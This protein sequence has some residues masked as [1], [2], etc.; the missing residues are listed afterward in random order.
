MSKLKIPALSFITLHLKKIN[1]SLY[2][3]RFYRERIPFKSLYTGA[4]LLMLASVLVTTVFVT[5]QK[6][7]QN[8]TVIPQPVQKEE[9][10]APTGVLIVDKKTALPQEVA[11]A[12]APV[13]VKSQFSKEDSGRFLRVKGEIRVN[14]GWH[15]HPLYNDWRYHTGVD[16]MGH[17]GQAVSA[18]HNGQVT[19]IFQDANSGLTVV[20]KHNNYQVYYGS[21]LKVSVAKGDFVREEQEIGKMGSCDAEPYDHLHL[22]IKENDDYVDPLL[23]LNKD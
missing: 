14:F 21:L 1:T 17:K 18:I 19:E 11:S 13:A 12:S 8:S 5:I 3:R 9:I 6:K 16:I 7:E 10:S 15:L 20:V 4:C 23:I 2:N 22:A